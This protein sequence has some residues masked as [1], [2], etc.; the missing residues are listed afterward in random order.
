MCGI[1]PQD[2][3]QVLKRLPSAKQESTGESDKSILSESCLQLLKENCSIGVTKQKW[4]SLPINI[5]SFR[6]L[7]LI[8]KNVNFTFFKDKFCSVNIFPL[9]LFFSSKEVSCYYYC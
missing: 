3:E 8:A 1:V 9:Y 4:A 5:K 6:S 2:M 7:A